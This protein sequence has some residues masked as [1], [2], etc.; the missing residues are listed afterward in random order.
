MSRLSYVA[1]GRSLGLWGWQGARRLRG[2]G[3]ACDRLRK[4]LAL[5]RFVLRVVVL[6][7]GLGLCAIGVSAASKLFR[8]TLD[9]PRW[10]IGGSALFAFVVGAFLIAAVVADFRRQRVRRVAGN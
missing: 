3:A 6:V 5:M 8:E 4:E 9:S 7:A 2:A 1:D 10:M